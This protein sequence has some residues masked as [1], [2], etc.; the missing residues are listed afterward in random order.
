MQVYANSF[1]VHANV[2]FLNVPA[3]AV[4]R[5]IMDKLYFMVFPFYSTVEEN[6]AKQVKVAVDMLAALR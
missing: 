4:R 3:I 6:L 1:T 2:S 5:A